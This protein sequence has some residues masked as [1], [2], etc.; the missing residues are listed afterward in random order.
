VRRRL[1]G[2]VDRWG[3]E[4]REAADAVDTPLVAGVSAGHHDAGVA[5]DVVAALRATLDDACSDGVPIEVA[6]LE[7]G[8]TGPDSP[9][10]LVAVDRSPTPSS[11][12]FLD[13]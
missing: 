9:A 11:D 10:G 3:G 2:A 4:L 13:T 7:P 1:A 12:A 8:I 6:F 5:G